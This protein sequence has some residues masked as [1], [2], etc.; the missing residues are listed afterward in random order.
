MAAEI[1]LAAGSTTAFITRW[2][3][4][5]RPF[6]FPASTMPVLFGA[7][8][9]AVLTAGSPHWG[10]LLLS[11]AAM[12][13]LQSGANILNDATDF[14]RGLDREPT[15]G[16]GAVVRRLLTPR[17][18]IR[19]AA[20][21]FGMGTLLGFFLA[22]QTTWWLLAVGA[23]GVT[24]GV[25]YTPGGAPALKYRGLGDVAV[26]CAFGLLGS[27]GSWM[28]QTGSAAWPPVIY[29]LPLGLLVAAILHANNW[30]DAPT[31]YRGGIL[32]PAIILGDRGSSI[33]F[34]ILLILP[35][36]LVPLFV[37]L[38]RW[39]APHPSPLPATCLASLAAFPVARHL[40]VRAR[41]RHSSMNPMD[42]IALDGAT[43]RLNLIFGL[44]LN[45]GLAFH[46]VLQP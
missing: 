13:L 25:L 4:A 31:D 37:T 29:A 26:F 32:T 40:L 22:W 7:L 43:A 5:A 14:R 41:R 38:P 42:F 24:L 28:V 11:L 2:W 1:P 39:V 6:S 33:Y 10:R 44:L 34:H 46:L 18:A 15:P 30:R 12:L 17:Q 9:A 21:L 35:F 45:A 23:T 36:L 19:G 8:L 20:L 27:L 3:V 16:S